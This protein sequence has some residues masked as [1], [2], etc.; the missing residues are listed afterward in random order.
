MTES[1]TLLAANQMDHYMNIGAAIFFPTL[2]VV[3]L[4]YYTLGPKRHPKPKIVTLK[5]SLFVVGISTKTS[6]ETFLQDDLLLWKEYKLMKERGVITN[7]KEEHSFIA[8]RMAS[9]S[10]D[11]WEYVFGDIVNDFS[12]IPVGL[13]PIEVPATTF[14]VFP[15]DVDDE[16]S[17]GPAVLKMEKY[18]YEK[19]LPK[20]NF[21]LDTN[22]PI[23]E[24]EYHDKRTPET[25]RTMLFYVAIRPKKG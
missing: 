9:E 13:K 17:W 6:K 4:L 7:K 5:N 15:I 2:F 20:S 8:L 11:N 16:R 1:L 24:I 14:A 21:E 25:T 3:L 10:E 12:E 19:W 18:I 22:Y 23:R